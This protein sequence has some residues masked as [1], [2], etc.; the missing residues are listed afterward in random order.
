[1]KIW[2]LEAIIDETQ[3]AILGVFNDYK[4]AQKEKKR[5]N[6]IK[7]IKFETNIRKRIL[8]KIDPND[9]LRE[10]EYLEIKDE[11]REFKLNDIL[12]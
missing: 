6:S 8:N 2:I 7:G 5:W 12:N 3:F 1:M 10:S 11:I 9:F 4:L